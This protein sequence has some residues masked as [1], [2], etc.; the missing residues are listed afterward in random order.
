M[1]VQ[2]ILHKTYLIFVKICN[3]V[4]KIEIIENKKFPGDVMKYRIRIKSLCHR[5]LKSDSHK[6]FPTRDFAC[7]AYILDY[8]ESKK[9]CLNKFRNRSAH[10]YWGTFVK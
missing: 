6:R 2:Q 10:T 4:S 9:G 8:G 7:W 1:V 3:A 5:D